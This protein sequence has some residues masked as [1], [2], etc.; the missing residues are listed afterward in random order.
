MIR[1]LKPWAYGPF[2]LL[3]NAE[4]HYRIG[5]DFDRRI[6]TV[7]FDNAIEVAI[8]TYLGL[9]PMQ[10]GNRQYP[11]AS[12]EQWLTNY[13][14][15]VGF[16]FQECASRQIAV[17]GQHDEI[18]WYH[19]VRNGQ[20][21]NGGATVP[22]RREL[23]G[24]RAAAMEVFAILFDSPD[25]NALLDAH[26]SA[27]TPVPPVPRTDE[28]DRLIDSAHGMIEVA[29]RPEYASDVLYALD[30]ERYRD[31]ALELRAVEAEPEEREVTS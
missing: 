13:H 4:L 3:L 17:I 8:T 22:Q 21:H 12:V 16:F 29:G 27:R 28:D 10:R 24:V 20:Y 15:K 5:E 19:E 1:P 23:D 26:V 7:G 9:H 31:V 11:R 18:V 30:P 25:V 2:E 14:A 6:A